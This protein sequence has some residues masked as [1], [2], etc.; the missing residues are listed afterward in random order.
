M[1]IMSKIWHMFTICD[2]LKLPHLKKNLKKK[3]NND[4]GHSRLQTNYL[5]IS[6]SLSSH[7]P[8]A[9]IPNIPCIL[10]YPATSLKLV[11]CW[12]APCTSAA[13]KMSKTN[14]KGS[15]LTGTLLFKV[16]GVFVGVLQLSFALLFCFF[17]LQ[18]HIHLPFNTHKH[19]RLSHQS[20]SVNCN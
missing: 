9:S 14:L 10:Q 20:F 1:P 13:V 18:V 8:Y 7:I 17:T 3:K 15:V 5:R 16:L 4:H 2:S 19:T 6:S 11:M 12:K